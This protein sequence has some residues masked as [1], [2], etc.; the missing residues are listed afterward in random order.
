MQWL[1]MKPEPPVTRIVL[2]A[3]CCGDLGCAVCHGV[4]NALIAR[5]TVLLVMRVC[6]KELAVQFPKR[7]Y[8]CCPNEIESFLLGL[9]NTSPELRL[10]SHNADWRL[11][12]PCNQVCDTLA[13]LEAIWKATHAAHFA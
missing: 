6:E 9:R 13:A 5:L 12:S 1:P 4:V 11:S 10:F 2:I 7:V 8:R 3:V